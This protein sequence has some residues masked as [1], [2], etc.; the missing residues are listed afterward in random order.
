MDKRCCIFDMDG[1]LVD[2]MG[3]WRSLGRDYLEN[4]GITGPETDRVLE[5]IR[6][7][8]MLQAAQLF[9]DTFHFPG[10][11]QKI[12]DE[13]NAV[14]DGH[15]R[16]DVP[17]K[18]GVEDYLKK[19]KARG[20]RLCVATAT[21]EALSHTC[22]QRL[23]VDQLFEFVLSCENTGIGKDRPDIYFQAAQKLGV[24][25]EEIAVFEDA[26]Y[27]ARTAKQ[28]GFYTVAVEEH[29]HSRQDRQELFALADEIITDWRTAL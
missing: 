7:M 17:L 27:A 23:G 2:S 15:Y 22:L 29:C 16:N 21:D 14:M 26:L 20:C 28:A 4:Q 19:L 24:R 13:M 10:P 11:P 6:P 5:L 8:T 18:P 1:T 3:Y 12:V 25:P 9:Q